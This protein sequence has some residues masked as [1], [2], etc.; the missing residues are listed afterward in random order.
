MN[1]TKYRNLSLDEF[2][3][4]LESRDGYSEL[5]LECKLRL[6]NYH[7]TCPICEGDIEKYNKDNTKD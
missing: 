2:L 5:L 4:E 1:I 3:T 7:T 6:M